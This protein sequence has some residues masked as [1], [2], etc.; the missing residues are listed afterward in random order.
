MVD[1]KCFLLINISQAQM[2]EK[3][4]YEILKSDRI[5]VTSGRSSSLGKGLI[6]FYVDLSSIVKAD[7]SCGIVFFSPYFT[8]KAQNGDCYN[9]LH[10]RALSVFE[11]SI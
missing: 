10:H 9:F 5:I 1:A 7:L 8:E 2:K 3:Q 4:Q 6:W 11:K